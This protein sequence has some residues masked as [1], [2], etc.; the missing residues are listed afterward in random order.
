MITNKFLESLDLN[1]KKPAKDCGKYSEFFFNNDLVGKFSDANLN[2]RCFLLDPKVRDFLYH[3]NFSATKIHA[4]ETMLDELSEK[5][6]TEE[7]KEFIEKQ[8]DHYQKNK[9]G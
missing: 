5:L 2:L 1:V 9:N 6:M 3:W 8:I 4:L 7:E